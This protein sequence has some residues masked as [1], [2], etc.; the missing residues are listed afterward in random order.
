MREKTKRKRVIIHQRKVID[1]L[2]HKM[3]VQRVQIHR[4]KQKMQ[5]QSQ[6]AE[7]A[8]IEEI[9]QAKEKRTLTRLINGTVIIH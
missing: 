2:R 1:G 9:K 7:H 3:A 4:M 5:S 6:T 8:L